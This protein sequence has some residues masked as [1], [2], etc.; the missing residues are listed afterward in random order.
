MHSQTCLVSHVD[1]ET[2][3]G[4]TD[5]RQT[6]Q[7]LSVFC[8]NYAPLHW[9]SVS[10]TS[11]S[12][13]LNAQ[14]RRF[15]KVPWNSIPHT[16][17]D[18]PLL[19]HQ[20]MVTSKSFRNILNRQL[21]FPPLTWKMHIKKKS[22][23]MQRK[24]IQRFWADSSMIRL[25]CISSV[26]QSKWHFVFKEFDSVLTTFAVWV[27]LWFDFKRLKRSNS[28]FPSHTDMQH[29]K[30]EKSCLNKPRS[31][32]CGPWGWPPRWLPTC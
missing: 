26:R 7:K 21:V 23:Y 27:L 14:L 10:P 13:T 28:I 3:G 5:N 1:L 15:K 24:G 11:K 16:S 29:E 25:A 18:T 19:K 9:I 22:I 30:T 4:Q 20:E 31:Y 32:F 12:G 6:S 8:G 2:V 17:G